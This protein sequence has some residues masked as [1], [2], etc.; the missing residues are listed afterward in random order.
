M[1]GAAVAEEAEDPAHCAGQ[2][3]GHAA[4][5]FS[6]DPLNLPKELCVYMLCTGDRNM[7]P[8]NKVRTFL[9][10]SQRLV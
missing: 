4:S 2:L 8:T 9:G 7:N 10:S 5:F 1:L 3:E 6:S